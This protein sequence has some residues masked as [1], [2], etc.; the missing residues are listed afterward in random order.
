VHK[1]GALPRLYVCLIIH[2]KTIMTILTNSDSNQ[3]G[4]K[5]PKP[6]EVEDFTI[7]HLVAQLSK[8]AS[9]LEQHALNLL[10]ADKGNKPFNATKEM[11]CALISSK[12][13]V[14]HVG[15]ELTLRTAN[16]PICRAHEGFVKAPLSYEWIARNLKS[17]AVIIVRDHAHQQ[18]VYNEIKNIAGLK[19]F[20]AF[21]PFNILTDSDVARQIKLQSTVDFVVSLTDFPNKGY[22]EYENWLH[23]ILNVNLRKTITLMC[24]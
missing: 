24:E 11:L 18:V 6:P 21:H 23:R 22:N 13:A 12:I 14:H 7:D 2:H 17:R 9:A 3:C 5:P 19:F 4:G 10:K 20:E 15:R 8:N 1:D 16:A